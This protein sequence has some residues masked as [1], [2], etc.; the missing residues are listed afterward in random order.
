MIFFGQ[1]QHYMPRSEVD[2]SC[3]WQEVKRG[4]EDIA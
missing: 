1:R 2:A 3:I 4:W